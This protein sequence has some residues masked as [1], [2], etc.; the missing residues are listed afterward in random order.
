MKI[1]ESK[2]EEIISALWFIA[3]FAA[4]NA[5]CPR[6]VFI[7]LFCKAVIDTVCSIGYAITEIKEENLTKNKDQTK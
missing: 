4:L 5:G 2:I 7:T 6:W 1:S 3:A